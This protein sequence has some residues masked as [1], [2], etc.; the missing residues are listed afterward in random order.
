MVFPIADGSCPKVCLSELVA[1]SDRAAGSREGMARRADKEFSSDSEQ[2][3]RLEGHE[4]LRKQYAATMNLLL[5]PAAE[6]KKRE[7]P[8]ESSDRAKKAQCA[9]EAGG[10][11]QERGEGQE[12][13]RE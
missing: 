13:H 10:Q 6:V 9:K 7:R 12:G 11:G 4:H 8:E 2:E 1:E 5:V 3:W